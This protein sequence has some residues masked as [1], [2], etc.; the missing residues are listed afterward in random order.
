MLSNQSN[1]FLD[2]AMV[3]ILVPYLEL[4]VYETPGPYPLSH[5]RGDES[6]KYPV[7]VSWL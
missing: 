5:L 6:R 1:L 3:T 7:P 2:S 4:L